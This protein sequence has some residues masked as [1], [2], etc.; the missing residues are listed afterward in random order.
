[1]VV[2]TAFGVGWTV[3]LAAL[4]RTFRARVQPD[5][6]TTC[7]PPVS[8]LHDGDGDQRGQ[9]E[10]PSAGQH[11]HAHDFL[12]GTPPRRN[13]VRGEDRQPFEDVQALG[14]SAFAI[15]FETGSALRS[16]C[17]VTAIWL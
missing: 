14:S 13:V 9:C 6:R 17:S 3:N 4:V 15:V 16:C 10:R 2:P 1:M 5:T 7:S 11:Q 12:G 8:S